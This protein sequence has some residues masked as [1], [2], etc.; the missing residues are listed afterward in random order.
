[1]ELV[2]KCY[3][4][5]IIDAYKQYYYIDNIHAEK[6]SEEIENCLECENKDKCIKCIED[7]YLFN[8]EIKYVMRN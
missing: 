3:S 1:M 2:I 7:Y 8:D 5:D 4:K 6:C